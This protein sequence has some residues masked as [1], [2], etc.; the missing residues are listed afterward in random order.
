MNFQKK[1]LKNQSKI[2]LLKVRQEEDKTEEVHLEEE[3]PQGGGGSSEGQSSAEGSSSAGQGGASEEEQNKKK[4]ELKAKNVL[5]NT[6]DIDWDSIKSE[7][8]NLYTSLPSITIDLYQLNIN[9]EEILAFNTEYDKLTGAVKDDKKE[10]TLVELTKVYA[11]LPKFLRDSG[12]E[13]VYTTLVETKDHI[14]RG[15]S[16]LDGENW[17]EISNDVKNAID[18][19]TKLLTNPNIDARKQYNISKAYIMLN[20]LQNAVN[21]QDTKVFLIKYKNLLEEINNI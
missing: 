6:D 9:Q 13:E 10:E 1:Q 3:N 5:T 8:E 16:K 18:S 15:Y 20:E 2:V 7:I 21:L 14:F 19:Y 12:Q 4:F 17:K 11:Y